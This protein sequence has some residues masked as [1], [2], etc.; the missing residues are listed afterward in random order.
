MSKQINISMLL[1]KKKTAEFK[2]E[3]KAG[4]ISISARQTPTCSFIGVVLFCILTPSKYKILY[5][6]TQYN[7]MV[8]NLK[9]IICF[10]FQKE[11]QNLLGMQVS[12]NYELAEL[13]L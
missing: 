1:K 12:M 4:T 6:P 2:T 5:F 13:L 8:K 9:P 3:F 7:N 10:S 11:D